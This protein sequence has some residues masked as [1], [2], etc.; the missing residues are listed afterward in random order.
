LLLARMKDWAVD[1]PH[2]SYLGEA[3]SIPD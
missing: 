1:L 3:I 2:G